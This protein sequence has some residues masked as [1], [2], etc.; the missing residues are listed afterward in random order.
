M[1]DNLSDGMQLGKK[2]DEISGGHPSSDEVEHKK[3]LDDH[4]ATSLAK[5]EQE[6]SKQGSTTDSRTNP[7]RK[8]RSPLRFQDEYGY[9]SP[10]HF[11]GGE[12]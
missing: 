11:K 6:V 1:V 3:V 5:D 9:P 7:S 12:V 8:H 2:D 10:I 4:Q